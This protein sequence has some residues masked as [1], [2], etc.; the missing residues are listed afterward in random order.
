MNIRKGTITDKDL[1]FQ[2][3]QEYLS[4]LSEFY[5]FDKDTNNNY[6]YEYFDAYFEEP[7]RDLLLLEDDNSVI[8]FAFIN[9]YNYEISDY[10]D[11]RSIAELY[12]RKEY[13]RKGYSEN[14][15]RT[16]MD[17]NY[18]WMIKPASENPS[19]S[20]F[21][22][23]IINKYFPKAKIHIQGNSMVYIIEKGYSHLT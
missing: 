23:F 1:A 3:L 10:T 14:F 5:T 18:T 20:Y 2:L 12:I 21:W 4:E 8:G 7:S 9:D 15:V 16:I 22:E 6:I 17:N 19:A 13:R 11:C